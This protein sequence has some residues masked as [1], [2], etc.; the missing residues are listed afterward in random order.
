MKED[1]CE[2]YDC[3]YP[4][5]SFTS[6][7]DKYRRTLHHIDGN[8][9]NNDLKNLMYV[10]FGC[11]ARLHHKGSHHS[12]EHRRKISE[13]SKGRHH[14]EET[15]RKIGLAS[16]DRMTGDKNPMFGKHHSEE[17][18]KKMSESS[19]GRHHSEETKRKIS[20]SMKGRSQPRRT[21]EQI[22]RNVLSRKIGKETY[23]EI[24]N[25]LIWSGKRLININEIMEEM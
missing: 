2:Y 16:K 12:E 20:E 14:S 18:K 25:D 13:S 22:A 11:H 24:E 19:K 7:H 5:E 17:S 3:K 21:P 23:A 15:R 8:H 1:T 10:H 6:S 4:D 9:D